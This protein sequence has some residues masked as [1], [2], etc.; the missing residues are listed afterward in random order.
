[1][2]TMIHNK[3]SDPSTA[4]KLVAL[5]DSAE[6][7]VRTAD[8]ATAQDIATL[9]RLNA[10]PSATRAELQAIFDG[11]DLRDRSEMQRL[12]GLRFAMKA[13][14]TPAQWKEITDHEQSLVG[15]PPSVP[16]EARY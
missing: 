16:A 8:G 4:T 5:L 7:V 6:T 13:L 10:Q 1:M 2:S 14:T 11:I 3:V 9:A 12:I 15:E